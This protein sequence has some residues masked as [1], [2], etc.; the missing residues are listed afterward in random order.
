MTEGTFYTWDDLPQ[1]DVT[2][3]I[4]RRLVSGQK[5]MSVQFVLEK[6]AIV[7]EHQ[8]PHEQIS[9]II[10]GKIEFVVGGQKQVMQA[11]DVLHIPSHV[12]HSAVALADT[13]NIE[14]FSPPREDFLST[15]TPDYMKS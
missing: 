2:P 12:S 15:E 6:G 13:L 7:A 14:I 10:S 1:T 8:H 9:H 4:K 11:G 3:K 5:V